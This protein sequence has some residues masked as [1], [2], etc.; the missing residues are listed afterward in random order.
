MLKV[1][2]KV[3]EFHADFLN[4]EKGKCPREKRLVKLIFIER[5]NE[6]AGLSM[7]LSPSRCTLL[8]IFPSC[9]S[10]RCY[11]SWLALTTTIII[12]IVR[13]LFGHSITNRLIYLTVL[14]LK[15]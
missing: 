14:F 9:L 11:P 4:K 13:L 3:T 12:I 10:H 15:H 6:A 5:V 8:I 1:F 2:I 7:R